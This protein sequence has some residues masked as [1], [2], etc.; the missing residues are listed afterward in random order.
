MSSYSRL[1]ERE[2]VLLENKASMKLGTYTVHKPDDTKIDTKTLSM[3]GTRRSKLFQRTWDSLNT[4]SSRG[5]YR[6]GGPFYSAKCDLNDALRHTLTISSKGYPHVGLPA[7][8]YRIYNTVVTNPIFSCDPSPSTQYEKI[9][10]GPGMWDGGVSSVDGY[11]ALAWSRTRPKLEKGGAGQ[12]IAELR[13]LPSMLL[14]SAKPFARM[15]GDLIR[16][17]RTGSMSKVYLDRD[18]RMHKSVA[19]HFLNH[20]FGWVPFLSDLMNMFDVFERSKEYIAQITRDNNQWVKRKRVLEKSSSSTELCTGLSP[21]CDPVELTNFCEQRL[22]RGAPAYSYFITTQ[23]QT[24]IVWAVGSF[25]YYRPEFDNTLPDYSGLVNQAKQM[26]ILH[27]A[28]V[29]PS[30]LYKITPWTWLGDWFTGVGTAVDNASAIAEDS[31]VSRYL[32]VMKHSIRTVEQ[33]TTFNFLSGPRSF[34]WHRNIDVKQ[35]KVSDSPYGFTLPGNL[36]AKQLAVLV[37][38]GISRG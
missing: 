29:N 6:S 27:G 11:D 20:Q 19:G 16:N 35:R 10:Q 37:A 25:K 33:V 26:L 21:G 15:Y 14:T 38:L 5:Y 9:G 12:A 31:I 8:Y 24:D 28:R 3:G 2:V 4:R 34:S 13:E 1:R 36:S 18:A 22:F 17:S 30:L 7:G 32:Y 23:H